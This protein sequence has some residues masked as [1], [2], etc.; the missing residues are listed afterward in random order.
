MFK[1]DKELEYNG[2]ILESS[3]TTLSLKAPDD[4][5]YFGILKLREGVTKTLVFV[6]TQDKFKARLALDHEEF[7]LLPDEPEFHIEINAS[8]FKKQ[9]NTVVLKID[10]DKMKLDLKRR[11]NKQY[12]ECMREV[13]KVNEKLEHALNGNLLSGIK[14][15]NKNSIRTGMVP[16]AVDSKG[17][18]V[19]TRPFADIVREVNGIRAFNESI[20]ITPK[21]IPFKDKTLEKQLQDIGQTMVS[22]HKFTAELSDNLS[23]LNKKLNELIIRF[24]THIDNDPLGG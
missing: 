5:H 17:N 24:E 21:D 6:K 3:D 9:S 1:Y 20:E 11:S 12:L 23:E 13:K 14:I 4:A 10:R 7:Q 22:L 18:F 19:A 16:V 2:E 8:E 15:S